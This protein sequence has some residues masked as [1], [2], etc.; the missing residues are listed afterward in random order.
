[1]PGSKKTGSG[2]GRKK[3]KQGSTVRR[4]M[5]AQPKANNSAK[6]SAKSSKSKAKKSSSAA[7]LAKAPAA[8]GGSAAKSRAPVQSGKTR[9]NGGVDLKDADGDVYF[10]NNGTQETSW[11]E[12][13]V[14]VKEVEK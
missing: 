8:K 13:D 14:G 10:F 3:Q 9:K 7:N 2:S 6:S 12:P 1:M 5:K 11:V 4:S